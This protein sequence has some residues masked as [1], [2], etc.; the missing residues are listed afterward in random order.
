L[1][2]PRFGR[3]DPVRHALV[4]KATR[5]AES[6]RRLVMFDRQTGLYAYWYIVQR[7]KEESKRTERYECPL[8]VL[9]VEVVQKGD[10]YGLQDKVTA[11]L[12]HEMRATDLTS[13]LGDGRFV[14]VLTETT[15]EEAGSMAARVAEHFPK[16]LQ[17][18]IAC[19]PDDGSSLDEV[20]SA[21]EKRAHG[22][23]DLASNDAGGTPR[24][25]EAQE[26]RGA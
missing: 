21:A 24:G 26:R 25:H 13:H 15:L 20:K 5:E 8:S 12:A 11:W 18:G 10:G 7:F 1:K 14:V 23:W 22:N 3:S 9:S 19:F 16:V 2:L 4:E 17:M 6:G